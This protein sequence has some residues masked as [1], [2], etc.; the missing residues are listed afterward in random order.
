MTVSIEWPLAKATKV[1]GRRRR[2]KEHQK[3]KIAQWPLEQKVEIDC[4]HPGSSCVYVET[5]TAVLTRRVGK[6]ATKHEEGYVSLQVWLEKLNAF[7]G[8]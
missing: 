2:Y 7:Y 6:Q 4:E 8:A 5:I 1:Y 3:G